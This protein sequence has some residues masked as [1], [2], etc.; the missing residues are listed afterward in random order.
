MSMCFHIQNFHFKKISERMVEAMEERFSE[1]VI[2][3]AMKNIDKKKSHGPDGFNG[4]YINMI[5]EFIKKDIVRLH[6]NFYETHQ[7]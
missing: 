3:G 6:Q 5:W 7:V 2:H 1:M 4:Y